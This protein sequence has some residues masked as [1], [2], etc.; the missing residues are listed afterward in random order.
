MIIM[1]DTSIADTITT[2]ITTVIA[3]A[4]RT[5][6]AGLRDGMT[7]AA[8]T[9]SVRF[10]GEPGLACRSRQ[11]LRPFICSHLLSSSSRRG[12]ISGN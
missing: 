9:V 10:A 1:T 6:D 3:V 8:I 2:M 11:L 12:S 7:A 4:T 5:P